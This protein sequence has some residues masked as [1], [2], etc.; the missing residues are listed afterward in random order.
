MCQFGDRSKIIAE[1]NLT[2][3][4]ALIGWR[5]N[6]IINLFD[7]KEKFI[8][9]LNNS[10]VYPKEKDAEGFGLKRE[11]SLGI[12]NYD[13]YNYNNNDDNYHNYYNYR[14]YYYNHYNN[15]YNN[16]HHYYYNDYNSNYDNYYIQVKTL[17][18]GKV[19]KY[20]SGYR[21][22]Y[23]M[24]THMVILDSDSEWFTDN[25]TI[26]FANHFNNTC[27]QLAKGYHCDVMEFSKRR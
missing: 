12:Y 15:N 14:N 17:H 3:D 19:F 13:N 25:K 27:E 6:Y 7:D 22:E 4:E 24:V 23:C 9:A 1:F 8:R 2:E 10:Y 20:S 11:N 26:K 18:Y 16:Y 5:N 21:S